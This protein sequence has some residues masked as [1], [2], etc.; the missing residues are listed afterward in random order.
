MQILI[1][2]VGKAM[3]TLRRALGAWLR[4]PR[5][6]LTPPA[7]ALDPMARALVHRRWGGMPI[8]AA[9]GGAVMSVFGLGPKALLR[10]GYTENPSGVR[11]R[12]ETTGPSVFRK[13]VADAAR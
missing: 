8:P 9:S 13:P 3:R 5:A 2:D 4:R 11:T 1:V 10:S 7:T 6:P 12:F